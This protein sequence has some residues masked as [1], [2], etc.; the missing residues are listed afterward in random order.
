[1]PNERWTMGFMH[2]T[3][4][5]GRSMRVLTVMDMFTREC[6]ALE[7]RGSFRGENMAQVLTGLVARSGRPRTIQC[8]QGTEFTS[9]ALDHW[10]YWNRVGISFSRP[11]KPGTLPA[12]RPSTGSSGVSAYRN[13][14]SWILGKQ[15]RC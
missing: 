13:I 11:G 4:F 1:M 14:T 3:L 15:L 8:D 5:D 12:T 10:A 6:R 9:M 7:V 2:D